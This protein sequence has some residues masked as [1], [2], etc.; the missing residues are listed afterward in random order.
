MVSM[1][2]SEVYELGSIN[3]RVSPR[4]A[5]PGFAPSVPAITGTLPEFN[6]EIILK[7]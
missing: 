4:V 5:K 2:I 6:Y 7:R 3:L 1:H